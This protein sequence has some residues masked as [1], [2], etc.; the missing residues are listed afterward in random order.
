MLIITTCIVEMI[1]FISLYMFRN[2]SALLKIAFHWLLASI[3]A[4]EK[5][6]VQFLFL[7]LFSVATFNIVLSSFMLC[8]FSGICLGGD[9]VFLLFFLILSGLSWVFWVWGLVTH[10]FW[11]LFTISEYY[12]FTVFSIKWYFP[13]EVFSHL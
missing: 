8:S 5:L 10:Q 9:L 13:L 1:C 2:F 6:S 7:C 3:V 12:F 11:K 4:V